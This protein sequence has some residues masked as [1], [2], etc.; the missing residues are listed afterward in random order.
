VPNDIV[1]DSKL[2]EDIYISPEATSVIDPTVVESCTPILDEIHE[3][4]EGTSDDVDVRGVSSTFI[5]TD[6]HTRDNNDS[7]TERESVVKFTMTALNYPIS[8]QLLEFRSMIHRSFWLF[9]F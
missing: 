1:G 2:V 4:P 5:P 3:F 6:V 9:F 8:N 7:Y